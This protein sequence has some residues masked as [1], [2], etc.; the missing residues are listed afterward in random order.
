MS[1]IILLDHLYVMLLKWKT[2]SVPD[3]SVTAKNL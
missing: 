2:W 3:W 1:E